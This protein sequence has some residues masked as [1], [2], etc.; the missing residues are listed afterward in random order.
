MYQYVESIFSE[1]DKTDTESQFVPNKNLKV[2]LK[3]LD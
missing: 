3:F 2:L 1:N